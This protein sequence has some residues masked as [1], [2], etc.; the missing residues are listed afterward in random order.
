MKTVLI[1]SLVQVAFLCLLISSKKTKSKSDLYLLSWLIVT[2]LNQVYYL[3]SFFYAAA[4]P[5]F[6]LL[7]LSGTPLLTGPL[8]LFYV[9]AISSESPK[10]K[11][12]FALHLFPFLT[13][14]VF[15]LI[16]KG[17]LVEHG[18][19]RSNPD[20]LFVQYYGYLYI[21]SPILYILLS[22]QAARRYQLRIRERFSNLDS[23]NLNWL[24]V[25][26]FSSLVFFLLGVPTV[27]LATTFQKIEH[28]TAFNFLAVYN[29]LHIFIIGYFGQKKTYIFSD[30]AYLKREARNSKY[31]KSGLSEELV[32]I[33]LKRLDV[34][35]E[36]AK[37]YLN[38][39]LSASQLSKEIGISPNHLSEILNL[40]KGKSFYHF[41]NQLRTDEV[42]RRMNDKKY[43]H[44]S[45]IGIAFDCGFNSRS[46]FSKAFKLN[47]GMSPTEFRKNMTS[48]S[49]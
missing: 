27:Y 24:S 43:A 36:D 34:H 10:W 37:P 42:K 44:L 12:E 28:N 9:R 22:L 20:N 19:I 29:T 46:T 14:L 16:T 15:V 38:P 39:D 5:G 23:I 32:E 33:Y 49:G 30:T 40:Y 17:L 31:V 41:I 4:V 13:F 26:I 1:I 47:T 21:I 48:P 6:I 2:G 7:S 25:W 3:L 35:I 18:I 8:F 45:N 11:W